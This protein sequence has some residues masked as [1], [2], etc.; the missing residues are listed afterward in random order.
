VE[1]FSMQ[2]SKAM[3][4]VKFLKEC[5]FLWK[6]N[7]NLSFPGYIEI[8]L[9]D[10]FQGLAQNHLQLH[11][12]MG[13]E[14]TEKEFAS[15]EDTI[16]AAIRISRLNQKPIP[17][18]SLEKESQSSL[19]EEGAAEHDADEQTSNEL[20]RAHSNPL[21]PAPTSL[22][23]SNTGQEEPEKFTNIAD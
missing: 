9:F 16:D 12:I 18:V 3:E 8:L 10:C 15:R 17:K 4:A 6:L 20:E 23:V 14:D 1:R 5:A 7:D 13:T 2:E 22:T 21:D 11:S 19:V